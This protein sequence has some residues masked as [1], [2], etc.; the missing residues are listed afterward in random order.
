MLNFVKYYFENYY[1][2][3]KSE[4]KVNMVTKKMF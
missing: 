3:L 1:S 2:N 4:I